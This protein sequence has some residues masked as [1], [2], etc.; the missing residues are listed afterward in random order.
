MIQRKAMPLSPQSNSINTAT[1]PAFSLTP[2][3][4]LFYYEPARSESVIRQAPGEAGSGPSTWISSGP[5][6][7]FLVVLEPARRAGSTPCE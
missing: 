5:A 3:R 1:H 7:L 4:T 2:S 6:R